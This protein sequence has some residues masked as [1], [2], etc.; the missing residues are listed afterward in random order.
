MEPMMSKDMFRFQREAF[1][2]MFTA[3]SMFQDHA[4]SA[5]R[6]FFDLGFMPGEGRHFYDNWMNAFK[7]GRAYFRQALD[8]SFRGV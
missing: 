2:N 5:T 4:E 6:M 7:K 1:N 3:L 8:E